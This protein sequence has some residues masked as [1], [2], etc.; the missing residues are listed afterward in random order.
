MNYLD[1]QIL[2]NVYISEGQ[3]R[4][5]ELFK[6]FHGVRYKNITRSSPNEKPAELNFIWNSRGQQN[7][8]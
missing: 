3:T 4:L 1:L 5:A 8:S 6:Y 2:L 7:V